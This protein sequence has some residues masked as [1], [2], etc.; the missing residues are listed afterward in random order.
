MARRVGRALR[1]MVASSSAREVRL[2]G[3]AA[4]RMQQ[5]I[6]TGRQI[7]V[8]SVRGGAGKTT[9]AALLGAAYAH[10]R[11]DPVLTMEADPTLGTLPLRAGATS[12]R[13]TMSDLA[14]VVE[15]SMRFDQV[16]G[17]LVAL[18]EGGWLLPG[19]RGQIGAQVGLEAYQTVAMAL[20][21]FFAVTVVDCATLPDE[22]AR[23]AMAGAQAR[24]LATPATVDGVVS[25]RAVLDWMAS[26]P[27]PMLRG[28]VVA[29]TAT[30][31]N[32]GVDL[33]AA[34]RYLRVGDARVVVLP[35]DRHVAAG[36]AIELGLLGQEIRVAVAELAGELL[37]QAVRG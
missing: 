1:Q 12:L 32:P 16:I 5:P 24:V 28:T 7:V 4:A 11:A 20:R 6:T 19:S 13:W 30:S 29:L 10:H 3:E 18:P 8:T 14:R 36:G 31:A 35:H 21:R 26:L 34:E 15:P 25:T 17:Y 33:A 23:S 27:R 2:A 9:I 22:V 37:S